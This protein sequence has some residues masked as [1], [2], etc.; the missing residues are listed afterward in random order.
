MT[1][2]LFALAL[3]CKDNALVF[4]LFAVIFDLVLFKKLL[5]KKLL[6]LGVVSLLYI[7]IRFILFQSP[8]INI[9]AYTFNFSPKLAITTLYV[10][11]LWAIGAPELLQDYLSSPFS[12][13]DRY[14]TDF[15]VTGSLLLI[16]LI[17]STLLLTLGFLTSRMRVAATSMLVLFVCAL[18]PVLFLPQHK[19]TIQMSISLMCFSVFV[20]LS[21]EQIQKRFQVFIM[22]CLLSLN[23][24]ALFLT[25]QTHYT[26]MRSDISAKAYDYFTSQYPSYPR[27][28]Y[29][30]F[31]NSY[32]PGSEL[33]NWG[34]SQQI[35]YALWGSNFAQVFYQDPSIEMYYEDHQYAP[36]QGKTAIYID[37][38]PFLA[39]Y[40]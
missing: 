15:S 28:H 14:F 39:R 17:L 30:V 13:I 23:I 11:G 27:N 21:L 25:Q 38:A 19:F 4:P 7:V 31:I 6:T 34:S 26:E 3:L 24:I 18:G 36:P 8:L 32:T 10:Y 37:S 2:V 33:T 16:S 22:S 20:A 12:V 9:D 40:P 29:F 35:S 5:W 1:G